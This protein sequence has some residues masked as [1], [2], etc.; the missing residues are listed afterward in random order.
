MNPAK[1]AFGVGSGKFLSLMVSQRC[2]EANPEKIKEILGMKAPTSLKEVQKLT[3]RLAALGRFISK[4]G[5][6]VY[7][8]LR[9]SRK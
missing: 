1:C 9:H 2:I 3:E 8:F 4:S 5:K 7:L 6:S